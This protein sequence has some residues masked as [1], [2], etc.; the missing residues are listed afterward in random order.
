MS[1]V[2]PSQ[3]SVFDGLSHTQLAELRTDH[4]GELGAVWIYKGILSVTKDR[5]LREFAE[6][7]LATESQHF[8]FFH[9][10]LPKAYQSLLSPLWKIAGWML[11]AIPALFGR[12][13]VYVTIDAVETFVVQHYEEQLNLMPSGLRTVLEGFM[14]DEGD[15]R[16]EAAVKSQPKNPL[17]WWRKIVCAGSALGV[18]VSRHL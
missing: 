4:A 15:H 14:R 12:N 17:R 6:E 3:P 1:E 5:E 18:R 2:N 16:D 7:H 11:G 13:A 10:G 9:E 8:R